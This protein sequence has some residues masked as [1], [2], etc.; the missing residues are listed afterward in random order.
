[1]LF[2][3]KQEIRL[4]SEKENQL[5]C[6]IQL[7]HDVTCQMMM[8]CEV[9]FYLQTPAYSCFDWDEDIYKNHHMG[10]NPANSKLELIRTPRQNISNDNIWFK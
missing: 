9:E 2:V 6:T 8:V 1:M 3:T 10:M 7:V 5:L 4:D